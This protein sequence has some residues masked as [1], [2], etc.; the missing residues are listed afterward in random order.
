MTVTTILLCQPVFLE[1]IYENEYK[2]GGK[3]FISKNHIV[4]L[5]KLLV[6]IWC[7]DVFRAM[8]F[9]EQA[10]CPLTLSPRAPNTGTFDNVNRCSV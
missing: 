3:L 1:V 6:G 7:N 10:Q 2:S 9:L 8:I 4:K 5:S